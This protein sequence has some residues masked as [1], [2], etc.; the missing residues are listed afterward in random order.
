MRAIA[1]LVLLAVLPTVELTEQLAHVIA[2]VI[3]REP[4]AHSAHHEDEQHGDEHGCTG[5]VHLCTCHHTQ[6][7]LGGD[8]I[9]QRSIVAASEHTI[10]A[11]ES[12]VD[13]TTQEPAQRPP[14]G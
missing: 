5:L 2:H 12:L 14:I 8:V 1:L 6:I 7:T 11:P 4:A 3:E 10:E 9:V 13:L